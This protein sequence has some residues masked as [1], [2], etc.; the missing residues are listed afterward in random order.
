MI[1]PTSDLN[2]SELCLFPRRKGT[3][4]Q[5]LCPL[6]QG[7]LRLAGACPKLLTA[8]TDKKIR[9]WERKARH[10]SMRWA[11]RLREIRC[12]LEITLGTRIGRQSRSLDEAWFCAF[13][14]TGLS[15]LSNKKNVIVYFLFLFL[16]T[17]IK[18]LIFSRA[19]VRLETSKSDGKNSTFQP[20]WSSQKN[21][22]VGKKKNLK[23]LCK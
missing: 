19:T 1:Y 10:N 2:H 3:M 8:S 9:E 11:R 7:V 12:W 17:L 6:T 15:P 21:K 5:V 22:H 20:M 4:G 23:I 16:S 18:H 14:T 13:C